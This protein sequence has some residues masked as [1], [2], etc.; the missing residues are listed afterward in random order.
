MPAGSIAA[1]FA[2]TFRL[3]LRFWPQ[4]MCLVLPGV[5]AND[6]LLWAAVH[7][8]FAHHLRGWAVLTLVAWAPLIDAVLMFQVLLPAMP[9][10]AAAP[11]AARGA[12]DTDRPSNRLVSA[13]T[14]ALLPFFAYYAAW[15]FLG[16]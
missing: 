4:L 7:T 13:V 10:L 8:A 12:A 11:A 1:P 9:A 2:L 6:V 16:D 14:I 3:W 15:G 5:L